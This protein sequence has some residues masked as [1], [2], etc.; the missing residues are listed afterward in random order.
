MKENFYF[1]LYLGNSVLN[2]Y[3]G[4]QSNA[5]AYFRRW[6]EKNLPIYYHE[7]DFLFLRYECFSDFLASRYPVKFDL[8]L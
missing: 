6:I 1:V 8:K 3:A 5:R 7:S 2:V 4:S